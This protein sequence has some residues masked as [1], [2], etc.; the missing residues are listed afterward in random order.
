MIQHIWTVLCTRSS[1]DRQTNNISLFEVI[2]ELRVEGLGGQPGVV[3]CPLELVSLWTRSDPNVP[4]RGEARITLHTPGGQ[5]PISQTQPVDL[6]E[7]RR[8]RSRARVP[9]LPVDQAGVYMFVVE[10]R[11]LGQEQ[12]LRVARI[13]LEVQVM[14]TPPQ[15]R[16]T[17]DIQGSSELPPPQ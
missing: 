3:P 2:E 11:E 10:C 14:V 1:I 13:P 8:L 5:T 15:E 6:Q 12:W 9:G 17:A 16:P 4:T 7:Y